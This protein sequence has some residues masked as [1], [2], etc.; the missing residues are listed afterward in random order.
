[1]TAAA[2]LA[3]KEA[4]ALLPVWLTTLAAMLLGELP[5]RHDLGDLAIVAYI[6]GGAALGAMS[7]GHE[8]LH[9]TWPQLLAQPISRVRLLAVKFGV[10]GALLAG[11][12]AAA[13]LFPLSHV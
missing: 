11:L 9:R 1:M 7:V 3:R 12:A 10:L 2:I 8:D 13:W 5:G 6:A 4:R